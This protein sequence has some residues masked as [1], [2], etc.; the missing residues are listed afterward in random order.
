[1]RD[2]P[3]QRSI[4]PWGP[5]KITKPDSRVLRYPGHRMGVSAQEGE[6]YPRWSGGGS[7]MIVARYT[8]ER[9]IGQKSE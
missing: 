5:W 8:G 6:G 2:A 3:A 7:R 1:M 9:L 4:R